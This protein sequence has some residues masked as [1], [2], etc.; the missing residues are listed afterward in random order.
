MD[1]QI[2][3]I[4]ECKEKQAFWKLVA[5]ETGYDNGSAV[6]TASNNYIKKW[7]DAYVSQTGANNAGAGDLN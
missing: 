1:K 5:R 2:S 6:Q 3:K 7:A 4:Y